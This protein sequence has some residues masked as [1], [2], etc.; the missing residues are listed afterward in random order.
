VCAYT[1]AGPET[2]RC[3]VFVCLCVYVCVY[4]SLSLSLS[5]SFS[6][7]PPLSLSL[8]ECVSEWT[9]RAVNK[10]GVALDACQQI[11]GSNDADSQFFAGTPPGMIWI[12]DTAYTHGD[13]ERAHILMLSSLLAHPWV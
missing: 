8:S 2:P 5:L 13:R 7:P 3:T 9:H 10:D 12:D 11:R 6:P 4:L 1:H